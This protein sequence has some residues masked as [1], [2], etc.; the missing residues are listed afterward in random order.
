MYCC[1]APLQ[2]TV[3]HAFSPT[4]LKHL[5]LTIVMCS[6][7]YLRCLLHSCVP[8]YSAYYFAH[9]VIVWVQTFLQLTIGLVWSLAV[10]V[11]LNMGR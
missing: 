4:V 2:L 3:G 11:V 10:S 7:F 6:N 9:F 8:T 5:L 1:V